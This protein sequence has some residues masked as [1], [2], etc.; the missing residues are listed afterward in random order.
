MLHY[1]IRNIRFSVKDLSKNI[2]KAVFSSFG[3]IF[4]IAFLVLYL[5]L[6]QSVKEYLGNTLFGSLDINEIVM[7]PGG[8]KSV[9]VSPGNTISVPLVRKV[10]GMKDFSRVYSLIRIDYV[11]RIEA[12]VMGQS[13]DVRVPLY[14]IEPG[15]FRVRNPRWRTFTNRIPVP[16]IMP[17]FGMQYLNGYLAQEGL[18]Q[19]T[20]KQ[21]I[22]YPGMI[23]ITLNDKSGNR[24]RYK[25]PA[26]LHSLSDAID[27][28]GVV[29]PSDFI[30]SFS[31]QHR[32]DSG[33]AMKGYNYVRL[34]ARVR[35]IKKLPEIAAGLEKMGLRVES[36]SDISKKTNRAMA[37]IDGMF[38]LLG[39]VM[40][41]LTFISIFNS[42]LVIAYNRSYDI[43]LKRVIGVSKMRII[44]TF[45][46]EA[47]F[48]GVILGTVGYFLGQYVTGLLSKQLA[49]WIPAFKGLVLVVSPENNLHYAILFSVA[50]SSVSALVPAVVASNKNLFRTMVQ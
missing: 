30:A 20:E 14:G 43:S 40:L 33:R 34:Y 10:R 6:R 5:T 47:A 35:D 46:F 36:R 31:A 15:F 50:V 17:K 49:V 3:I 42:Y 2:L 7:H 25:T 38:L 1:I 9:R 29:V 44:F 26:E 37:V 39:A 18:P 13:R 8:G 19:F 12:S 11:S 41:V 32:M 48:I 4:L 45:V 27:F 21:L 24:Q 23:K 22:G 16:I 28:P